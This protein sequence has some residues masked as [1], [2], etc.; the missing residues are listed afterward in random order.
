MNLE[1]SVN[2]CKV[3]LIEYFEAQVAHAN[4]ISKLVL[5]VYTI[6]DVIRP[7]DRPSVIQ[8]CLSIHDDAI[9]AI[10]HL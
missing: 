2:F 5:A 4:F 10:N 7:V 1:S 9:V 3:D 8:P 6:N